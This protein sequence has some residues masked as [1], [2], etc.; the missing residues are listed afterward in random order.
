[1]E[2]VVEAWE[3]TPADSR[4]DETVLPVTHGGPIRLVLG[5]VK[6]LDIVDTVLEQ[7]QDNCS[8]T[9]LAVDGETDAVR[10]LR[11]NDT[12]HS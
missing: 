1:M 4:P 11:E 5:D 8:I 10:V 2:R 3:S 6:D 7:S 9:E 12:E